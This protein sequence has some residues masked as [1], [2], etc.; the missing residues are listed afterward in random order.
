MSDEKLSE[1]F[2]K[3]VEVFDH[4]NVM[5]M[6]TMLKKI[7]ALESRLAQA[8]EWV[9]TRRKNRDDIWFY[10]GELEKTLGVEGVASQ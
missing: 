7:E 10:L 3:I 1:R 2:R 8:Q 5:G 4:Y 6:Q 9:A